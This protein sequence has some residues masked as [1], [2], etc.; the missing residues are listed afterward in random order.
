MQSPFVNIHTHNKITEDM[1]GIQSYCISDIGFSQEWPNSYSVGIH[2]W[3]IHK[4]NIEQS[5]KQIEYIASETNMKAVGECGLDRA[6]ARNFENQYNTFILQIK[7]AEAFDKPMIVHNVRAFSDYLGI[8]KKDKPA[9]PFIFHGFNGNK[10][11]LNK[12]IKFN[13]YFSMGAEILINNSKAQRIIP[14][15]PLNRLFI[16]TDEWKGNIKELYEYVSELKKLDIERIKDQ[17]YY[18]YKSVFV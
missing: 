2:P 18:N 16:E 10:D 13:V 11:I 8:L 14:H 3:N 9:I 17:I 12:L 15:I 6:I 1:I 7:I 5:I 4:V